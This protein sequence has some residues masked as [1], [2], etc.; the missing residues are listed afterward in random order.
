M[1]GED[2]M[3]GKPSL[4]HGLL[5]ASLIV[6]M[7]SC[8]LAE[9]A[10]EAPDH[11]AQIARYVE[12]DSLHWLSGPEVVDAIK[13][14]NKKTADLTAEHVQ[15]LDQN[16]RK[17]VA[18]SGAERAMIEDFMKLPLSQYLRSMQRKTDFMV[19]EII[20]TDAK[21]LNVG[22]STPS[23]DFWQGDEAK[24]QETF[25]KTS[26]D[27]FIDEI[28]FEPETGLLISQVSRTVFD[29]ETDQAVG[30]I[31]ISINMNKL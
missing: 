28:E 19:V 9:A 2:I 16:W 14:Q 15:E 6:G 13:A 11:R 4:H 21:G 1:R 17:A 30:A 25:G 26:R 12:S 31:T 7:V 23:S 29:P 8:G 27:L 24:H 3:R 22:L 5:S 10:T 20:V 18:S